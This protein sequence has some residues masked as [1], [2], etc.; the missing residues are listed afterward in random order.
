MRGERSCDMESEE[1]QLTE[2]DTTKSGQEILNSRNT[3]L[4]GSTTPISNEENSE[5]RFEEMIDDGN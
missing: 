5:K 3:E 4:R 2:A 1:S